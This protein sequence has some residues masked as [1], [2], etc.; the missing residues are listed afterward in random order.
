MLD[1]LER[2]LWLSLLAVAGLAGLLLAAAT[3]LGGEAPR[4][5]PLPERPGA[6][7]RVLPDA[8]V[9]QWFSAPLVARLTPGSNSVDIVYTL[10]FQPPP[11]PPPPPTKKVELLFQGWYLG[12]SGEQRAFVKLGDALLILTN[13]AKVVADHTI[14][15]IGLRTL[16][17]TNAAGQTNVLP[18]NVKK[19]VDVPA[20]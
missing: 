19:A 18:F 9:A 12:S 5:T 13:G 8:G 4:L 16:T 7:P 11:P 20:S 14:K 17:L 10:H 2:R 15:E 3:R 6:L 1:F